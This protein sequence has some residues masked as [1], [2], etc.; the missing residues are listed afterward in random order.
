LQKLPNRAIIES[1]S[2]PT[3]V[4]K[5]PSTKV[6]NLLNFLYYLNLL[7]KSNLVLKFNQDVIKLSPH[8]LGTIYIYNVKKNH[9]P[10]ITSTQQ[11]PPLLSN[12]AFFSIP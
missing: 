11:Q 1:Y 5:N 8:I 4:P 6:E 9:I 2:N 3:F 10:L 7:N 12:K